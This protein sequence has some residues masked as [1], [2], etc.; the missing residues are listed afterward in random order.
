QLGG[1][2]ESGGFLPGG[3]RGG[4]PSGQCVDGIAGQGGGPG[5]GRLA[6]GGEAGPRVGGES[7]VPASL[8]AYVRR[9]LEMIRGGGSDG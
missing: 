7:T 1:A 2:P 5:S 9:Y 6:P 8:R 3:G 4:G